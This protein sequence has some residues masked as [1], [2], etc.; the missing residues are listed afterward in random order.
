MKINKIRI[1]GFKNAYQE[2]SISLR[3]E[4]SILYG[5]NGGGK[6]TVLKIIHALL[7]QREDILLSEKV[8]QL[9]VNYS[10]D[11][12]EIENI[13]IKYNS[14]EVKYNWL[15]FEKSALSQS[16]SLLIGVQRGLSISNANVSPSLVFDFMRHSSI[17]RELLGST[18]KDISKLRFFAD[19][20]ANFLSRSRRT[21]RNKT[22]L[23]PIGNHVI[24]D[25]VSIDVINLALRNAY[26]RVKSR[27]SEKIY[28]ALF[29]TFALA[30][31]ESKITEIQIPLN[32]VDIIE[33]NK[34][35]LIEAL[36][37]APDNEVKTM[38]IQR[39]EE[40]S[41]NN[42]EDF[43]TNK[44]FTKLLLQMVNELELEKEELGTLNILIETFNLLL[45]ENKKMIIDREGVRINVNGNFHDLDSLSSGERHLLTF[46]TTILLD[47]NKRD[48]I[49]IDEPEISLNI[50]WQ[51]KL[52]TL[53]QQIA[54][55]SQIIVAS[56][57]QSIAQNHTSCLI[58]IEKIAINDNI[59]R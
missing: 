53:I 2:V 20:L 48:I 9:Y 23:L 54:P 44:L 8:D 32:I 50:I 24:M 49:L 4:I 15:E 52:L 59:K 16:K 28:N 36:I 56:H 34:K 25:E 21:G 6:T 46:L 12:A 43:Q 10:N 19:E 40:I 30:I 3:P 1:V 27:I 45:G 38:V 58:E 5:M 31:D 37:D 17:S 13:T 39:L 26:Y 7:N 18:N 47:G 35:R 51:E 14:K 41:D 22:E 29:E 57:S 55:F 42:Y 11:K 33:S